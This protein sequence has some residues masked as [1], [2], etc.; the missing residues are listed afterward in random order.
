MEQGRRRGPIGVGDFA[1][2][3]LRRRYQLTLHGDFHY[4]VMTFPRMAL[5]V[6]EPALE[7]MVEH[8]FATASGVG[9]VFASCLLSTLEQHGVSP[10]GLRRR[11]TG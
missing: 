10:S 4:C 6:P 1:R 3:D 7:A 5:G 9:Q 8:A 11:I 2:Y